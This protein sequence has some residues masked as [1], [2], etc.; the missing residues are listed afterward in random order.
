M[1][2][3]LISEFP[4]WY[5][6]VDLQ[7]D[8]E[9]IN[10]RWGSIENFTETVKHN[11][12]IQLVRLFYDI[13]PINKDFL[14]SF[15]KY[16][17][18]KD[19]TIT[20][21]GNRAEIRLLSGASLI[22]IL[23]NND[24]VDLKN[25]T[26]LTIATINFGFENNSNLIPTVY[27]TAIEYL[28]RRSQEVRDIAGIKDFSEKIAIDI[29][30]GSLNSFELVEEAIIT[31]LKK[32]YNLLIRRQNTNYKNIDI[33]L[34]IQQEETNVLWWLIGEASNELNC[35]LKSKNKEE[36]LLVIAKELSDLTKLMPGFFQIHF[37]IKKALILSKGKF[38]DIG[39]N[40]VVNNTPTDWKRNF[41]STVEHS[42]FDIDL[43][44]LN[45]IKLSLE[46]DEENDWL[47]FYKNL[48]KKDASK[49]FEM[50]EIGKQFYNELILI[51]L[52]NKLRSEE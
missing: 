42:L 29:D 44:I 9:T 13:D 48:T 5:R 37:F 24:N 30:K 23:R 45:C 17:Q 4:D 33:K 36:I 19:V 35:S 38:V 32:I 21:E 25:L 6:A 1:E 26:A 39:L 22:Q 49:K 40:E 3:A 52:K 28:N 34:N 14:N 8:S 7:P 18:E 16:F 50:I 10:E 47:S 15:V 11:D 12:I 27:K 46:T 43:P 51:R 41:L 2:V 20:I 31:N